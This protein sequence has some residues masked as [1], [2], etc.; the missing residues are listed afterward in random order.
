[1]IHV[2]KILFKSIKMKRVRYFFVLILPFLIFPACEK[3]TSDDGCDLLNS[4]FE[5]DSAKLNRKVLIIGIDGIRSDALQQD[6]SP[7]LHALSLEDDVYFT[8]AHTV[9]GITYSGPNWSSILTGV[10]YRKHQ[11]DDNSFEQPNYS[12]YKTFF[13]YIE[14]VDSSINTASIVNWTPINTYILSEVVDYSPTLPI[15]DLEVFESAQNMLINADPFGADVLFLHFDELDAAGHSFGFSYEVPEYVEVLSTIDAYVEN[16]YTTIE[17]KRQIGEEWLILI[18]SDHG[19]E[20][21][22]HG[23]GGNPHINKT[24][25][26]VQHP[27]I[28]FNHQHCSNQTDLTPSILDFLGISNPVIDC[29]TDGVS[30]LI[31]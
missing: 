2:F 19:G 4:S 5:I 27:S 17:A 21:F 28:E 31:Q 16:L 1:M 12:E 20:G 7:F 25:F 3:Y 13:E 18:V 15:N 24:V 6:S 26:F 29:K 22:G 10:H 8:A 30:I 11:V 14:V 9:E 23:D